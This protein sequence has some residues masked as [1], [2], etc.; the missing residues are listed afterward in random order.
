MRQLPNVDRRCADQ[1]SRLSK[2]QRTP[3]EMLVH[4]RLSEPPKAPGDLDLGRRR[5]RIGTSSSG[6]V[7]P[8]ILSINFEQSIELQDRPDGAT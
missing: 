6:G 8:M 1:T 5:H 3:A 4:L 2:H 7:R